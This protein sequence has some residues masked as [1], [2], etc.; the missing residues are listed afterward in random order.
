MGNLQLDWLSI[1]SILGIIIFIGTTLAVFAWLMLYRPEVLR[2]KEKNAVTTLDWRIIGEIMLHCSSFSGGIILMLNVL[3]FVVT[4]I[5]SVDARSLGVLVLAFG[6]MLFRS[7][8]SF[9][10]S[11][12]QRQVQ[13]K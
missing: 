12:C 13:K 6:I 2:S 1:S 3:I 9:V 7:F 11:L 10:S 5:W 4:G 8:D